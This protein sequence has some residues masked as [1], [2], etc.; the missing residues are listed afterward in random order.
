MNGVIG[1]CAIFCLVACAHCFAAPPDAA[2]I[3]W[4]ALPEADGEVMISAQEWPFEPGPREVKVYLRYPGGRIENVTG[5]TGL[6]LT[7][8]N[9]GGTGYVG[10]A[11]PERVTERYNVIAIGV[12][13]LQSGPYEDE[14]RAKAPY[15]FGYLQ[16]LDALRALYY[17]GHALDAKAI[18]YARGRIYCTGGSGGGNVT[19]MANK[20]APRTFACAVDMC[21]MAKLADDIAYG[22]PGRT[23]LNAGYSRDAA[24]AAYLAPDA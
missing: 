13:Y 6:M 5:V 17:V 4:P 3:P 14:D 19:L 8:H 10:T 2:S 23:R 16:A 22:I 24:S 9:W 11:D 21:G 15:D 7:L 12:D 1:F 18:G 20:L